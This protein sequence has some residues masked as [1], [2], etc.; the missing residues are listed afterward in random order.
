[1]RN[2][3][4]ALV[5][6]LAS[7]AAP[8]LRALAGQTLPPANLSLGTLHHLKSRELGEPRD[9]LVSLPDNYATTSDSFPILVLFDA[10][11]QLRNA[12]ATVRFY[13]SRNVIPDMIVLGIVNGPDRLR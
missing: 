9:L 5:I 3:A 6:A 8:A 1:M 12:V 4:L 2:Q 11:D 10:T 13:A 7:I